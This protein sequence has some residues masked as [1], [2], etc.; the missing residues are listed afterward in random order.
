MQLVRVGSASST[1]VTTTLVPASSTPGA[2]APVHHETPG[3]RP[4]LVSTLFRLPGVEW[5]GGTGM[6]H[7]VLVRFATPEHRELMRGILR[8]TV[9]RTQIVLEAYGTLPPPPGSGA[10][11]WWER[12]PERLRAI[13]SLPGVVDARRVERGSAIDLYVDAVEVADHLRGILR[14]TIDG[15][16]V[17]YVVAAGAHGAPT[18]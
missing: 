14:D 18:S 7:E 15:V 2:P 16:P 12:M 10:K 5:V 3:R 4:Y 8:E 17:R 13:A 9:G 11:P 6:P 1:G